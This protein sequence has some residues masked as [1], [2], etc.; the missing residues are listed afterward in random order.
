MNDEPQVP[1][2]SEAFR[3]MADRIDHN[4]ESGFG[5]ACVFVPP[6][7]AGTPIEVLILDSQADIAQFYTTV[8][9]RLE[10]ALNQIKEQN[11]QSQ[12]FGRR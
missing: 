5:G 7:G 10:I 2:N 11:V 3:R 4:K 1:S 8:A 12:A 9:T 6:A